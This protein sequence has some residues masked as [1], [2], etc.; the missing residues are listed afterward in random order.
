MESVRLFDSE[1]WTKLEVLNTKASTLKCPPCAGCRMPR[2][3]CLS[4]AQP[5]LSQQPQAGCH[6]DKIEGAPGMLG[7]LGTAT[8]DWTKSREQ[9]TPGQKEAFMLVRRNCKS[10]G[11]LLQPRL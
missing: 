8:V 4:R 3:R 11:W 2:G 5:S 9:L 1:D 10:M 7:E 6:C